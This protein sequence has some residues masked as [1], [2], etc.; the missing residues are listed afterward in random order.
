M[1]S[2]TYSVGVT[3]SSY[4]SNLVHYRVVRHLHIFVRVCSIVHL[5][6]IILVSN[7]MLYLETEFRIGTYAV[8]NYCI[9]AKYM[10]AIRRNILL[11]T[12]HGTWRL[13]FIN[14]IG[15]SRRLRRHATWWDLDEFLFWNH[16]VIISLER[17]MCVL[18]LGHLCSSFMQSIM[19]TL[20]NTT[21]SETKVIIMYQDYV[22]R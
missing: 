21:F 14:I 9:H 7:A 2:S 20:L 13:Q 22:S 16:A 8:Y 17:K 6:L 19:T 18:L 11:I 3:H 10:L 12:Q 4:A 15:N 1:Y 5:L